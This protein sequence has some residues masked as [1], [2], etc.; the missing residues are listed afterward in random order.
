MEGLREQVIGKD[1]V[2]V[3]YDVNYIDYDIGD[4]Y[5]KGALVLHTFRNVLNDDKLWSALLLGIQ[6]D[7]SYRTINTSVLVEYINAKTNADYS[8]FYEQY[9]N[10]T[11]LPKLMLNLSEKGNTLMV[12][13]RWQAD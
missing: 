10:H 12:K 3:V 4:M 7:F 11:S 13:Y 2:V 1:P 8:S 5:S 9:L 6:R